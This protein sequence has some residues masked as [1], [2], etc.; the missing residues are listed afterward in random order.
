MKTNKAVD[1]EP[2]R[3]LV[4]WIGNTDLA[5]MR[6]SLPPAPRPELPFT[7]DAR[8]VSGGGPIRDLLE[9]ER[10]SEVHL[11]S[12]YDPKLG[13]LF[14]G[15][16]GHRAKV[17][18]HSFQLKDPTV[19][20]DILAVVEPFLRER[21]RGWRERRAEVCFHLSPGTPSM[22]AVWVLLGKSLYPATLYQNYRG[23][24]AIADIPLDLSVEY[25][26]AVLRAPDV[27]L[28]HLAE[29]LPG[30]VQ[31]FEEI[32][33]K[34]RALR[35]AVG[36]ARRV[37]LRQVSVL[38]LGESGTGK[39]LFARAI[40]RGGCRRE[41]AFVAVNC[42]AIP[43]NM[44]E[45]E[46]FGYRRGAFTGAVRDHAGAFEQADGGTLFLDEIGECSPDMQAKLL[47]V[48]Q[49][50][51]GQHSCSRR[52]R[53]VGDSAEREVNVRVIAATNRNLLQACGQGTFREDLYYRLA[54]VTLKL[55]A[56]RER[57][58]DIPLL[59][60]RFLDE[61]N[62]QFQKEPGYSPRR[63]SESAMVLLRRHDWPGN[64]RELHNVLVQAAVM[65]AG[66]AID[67]ADVAAALS[68][69]VG[70]VEQPGEECRLGEGFDMKAY[71]DDI[72]RRLVLRAMTEA[73][74]VKKQAARLL[75]LKS[76]QTLDGKIHRLGVRWTRSGA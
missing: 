66:E 7:Y 21:Y 49:P 46:L 32:T 35:L 68:D 52:V 31:G 42:A 48:L 62:R 2:Q 34:S 67:R 3:I 44:L 16:L 26:P 27:H 5:A 73:G 40:H 56:L 54:T 18:L 65:A 74:G 36:R 63:L 22:A 14:A 8:R 29:S 28:Q 11:L 43:A 15:W 72:E 70:R 37:A 33:G 55:P 38:I 58:E 25:V 45:A 47:R 39:E 41:K 6:E 53:R 59:A 60:G 23:R 30:K 75:G 19:H 51:E 69:G 57:R 13:R 71:L 9:A 64:V 20:A 24:P 1:D 12:A 61:I 10:F 76:Y 50:V 17:Q 4:C